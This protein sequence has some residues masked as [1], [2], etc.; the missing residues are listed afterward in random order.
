MGE[1]VSIIIT[2]YNKSDYIKE[3][4]E[5]AINQTYK[6]VEVVIIDDCS[7][8]N[9]FDL[10]QNYKEKYNNIVC[11]R[12]E[13]NRGVVYSRNLAINK[14]SGYYILPLDADDVIMDI[15]VLYRIWK[16]IYL[17]Y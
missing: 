1:K 16:I 3:A 4:I 2:N 12:N 17:S 7:T 9:S 6:N 8:D 11:I 14:A 15:G 13:Q 5:S 10:I